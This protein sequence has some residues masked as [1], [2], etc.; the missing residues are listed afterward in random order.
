MCSLLWLLWFFAAF[1]A[2]EYLAQR[3]GWDWGEKAKGRLYIGMQ[4]LFLVALPVPIIVFCGLPTS[5]GYGDVRNEKITTPLMITRSLSTSSGL[6][7]S[8]WCV[9][10]MR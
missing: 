3:Y 7:R 2:P 10:V 9:A 8:C 6:R 4:L 1:S 5:Y